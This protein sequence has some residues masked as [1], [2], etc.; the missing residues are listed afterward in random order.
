[1]SH[2]YFIS[3][4]DQHEQIM[5]VEAE[6]LGGALQAVV[7]CWEETPGTIEAEIRYRGAYFCTIRD[8]KLAQSLIGVPG[9][10]ETLARKGATQWLAEA[11]RRVR[12]LAGG[13]RELHN[14]KAENDEHSFEL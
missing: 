1:M 12:P 13:L 9:A 10:I 4:H 7:T 11:A 14:G 2:P 8:P 3:F 6:D 5:W